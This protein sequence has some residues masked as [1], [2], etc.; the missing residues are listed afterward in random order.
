MSGEGRPLMSVVTGASGFV[1]SHLVDRLL[2]EGHHVVGLDEAPSRRETMSTRGA[3]G[4]SYGRCDLA[5]SDLEPL[6][7]GATTVFHLAGVSGVRESWGDRYADYVHANILGTQRLLEA[8]REA[9]VRRVVIASSSSVYGS[10]E[11][12]SRTGDLPR[13]LSPYGV[14]KLAAERLAL[15]YA[16]DR[17]SGFD[18]CVLRY[19][20]IY[21]PRQRPT[22]LMSRIIQAAHTGFPMTV[23]GDGT[24]KRHF[25]YV[26]DAV[27]ATILAGTSPMTGAHVVNVAGPLSVSVSEVLT[28]A[29]TVLDTPIPVHHQ[30]AWVGDV[31]ASEADLGET[32]ALL[33][34][35][36]RV[37]LA[38]GIA[39]HGE[40]YRTAITHGAGPLASVA[41]PGGA[42]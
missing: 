34:Y 4:F 30:D 25:T 10:A 24:Q 14:S 3:S 27:E 17:S 13:P 8:C 12:P 41:V 35:R 28:T 6:L 38:E 31:T 7:R 20:T 9:E 36:P 11:R 18:V 26:D 5:V 29:E 19:F 22:M 23:F 42:R 39:F 37:D 33:G 21:G 40:W 32:S 16:E 2:R 1:G 15:A